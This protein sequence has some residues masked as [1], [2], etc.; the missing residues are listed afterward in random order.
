[1][2]IRTRARAA[3]Q[4]PFLGE[5]PQSSRDTTVV[6]SGGKEALPMKFGFRQGIA[7]AA[8][9]G[10]VLLMVVSVDDRVR[11]RFSD[12]VSGGG[13]SLT[14]WGDRAGDLINALVSAVRYQS[15]ENAPMLVFAAAGAILVAFMLKT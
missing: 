13:N 9:F 10:A 2:P 7:S 4:L 15:I 8:V 11:D 6:Y 3:H 1:L 5:Q 12:L 14:P